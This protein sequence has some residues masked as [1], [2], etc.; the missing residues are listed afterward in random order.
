MEAQC[1]FGC[2]RPATRLLVGVFLFFFVRRLRTRNTLAPHRSARIDRLR[3]QDWL[4]AT[5][6]SFVVRGRDRLCARHA[7]RRLHLLRR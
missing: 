3:P 4:G 6:F 2:H 1:D 5:H 7:L